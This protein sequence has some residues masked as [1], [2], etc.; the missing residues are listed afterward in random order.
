[1]KFE[2]CAKMASFCSADH[3]FSPFRN[4]LCNFFKQAVGPPALVG[5]RLILLY[6]TLTLATLTL[7]ILTKCKV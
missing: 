5:I 3:N 6:N 1:M 7:A 4:T 2:Q